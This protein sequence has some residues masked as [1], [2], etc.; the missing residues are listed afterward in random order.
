M[1]IILNNWLTERISLKRSVRQED[2][3]SRSVD[4]LCIEVLANL[5]NEQ[6]CFIKFKTRGAAECFRT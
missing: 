3:L 2:A 6:E 4:V 5:I 1:P